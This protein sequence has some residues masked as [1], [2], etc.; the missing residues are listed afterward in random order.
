[1]LN[2]DILTQDGVFS[3]SRGD[4]FSV[5]LFINAGT[6]WCPV[7]YNFKE[8]DTL[9]FGVMLPN[10]PF[11]NAT[12][13]KKYTYKDLNENGDI[14]VTFNTCDTEYLDPG[15]YYYEAKLVRN[16][17]IVDTVISKTIINIC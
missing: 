5:P 4:S 14:V 7:R 1:M 2:T 3:M 16:E 10:Q 11:E 17:S 8:N 12:I 13:R 6:K 9:Y 15:I